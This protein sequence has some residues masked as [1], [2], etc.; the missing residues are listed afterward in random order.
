MGIWDDI[1]DNYITETTQKS[2]TKRKNCIELGA[3]CPKCK[4]EKL[5]YDGKLHLICPACGYEIS[6]GFT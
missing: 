1:I 3:I 5:S 6:S 4:A 2:E